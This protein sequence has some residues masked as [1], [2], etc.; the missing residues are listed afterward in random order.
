MYL[1]LG[2]GFFGLGV[3]G[4][5]LPLLPTTPFMILA[6]WAFSRSSPRFE[7]W[8]LNHKWFGPAVVR[9]RQHRVVPRKAKLMSWSMMSITFSYCAI[10]GRVP[11]WGL[12]AQALLMG[13][14]AWYVGRFPESSPSSGED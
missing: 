7:H 4:A 5:A 11:W 10:S 1:G 3:L 9:F 2:W 6:A 14:G 13:Y 8:L 12:V